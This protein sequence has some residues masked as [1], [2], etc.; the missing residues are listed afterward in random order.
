MAVAQSS[1]VSR[2][3]LDGLRFI[4][5]GGSWV[6]IRFSGTEPLIRTYA[7]AE[8]AEQ[9]QRLLDDIRALAGA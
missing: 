9:V 5:D 2:D 3:S 1:R 6:M 4:L 7:E 8:S